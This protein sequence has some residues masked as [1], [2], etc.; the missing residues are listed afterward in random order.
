MSTFTTGEINPEE[1]CKGTSW[2]DEDCESGFSDIISGQ[3]VAK[4]DDV[5]LLEKDASRK[6]WCFSAKLEG[7]RSAL[8]KW[9]SDHMTN[10]FTGLP[11]N[12][13][14]IEFV[15]STDLRTWVST[16]RGEVALKRHNA[17]R[18]MQGIALLEHVINEDTVAVMEEMIDISPGLGTLYGA[19]G[20]NILHRVFVVEDDQT[21]FRLASRM[22]DGGVSVNEATFAGLTLLHMCTESVTRTEFLLHRGANANISSDVVGTPLHVAVR[23]KQPDT[24]RALVTGGADVN[25]GDKGTPLHVAAE[26]GFF[27]IVSLLLELGANPAILH[28]GVDIL[29]TLLVTYNIECARGGNVPTEYFVKLKSLVTEL[30]QKGCNVNGVD[31]HF[32]TPLKICMG[33]CSS[34]CFFAETRGKRLKLYADILTE[35]YDSGADPTLPPQASALSYVRRMHPY[36]RKTLRLLVDP[37]PHTASCNVWEPEEIRRYYPMLAL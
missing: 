14:T 29:F 10:P 5:F 2:K 26:L 34:H 28:G 37:T 23:K 17:T 21:V 32:D 15:K 3:C 35:I 16:V 7:A 31:E 4:D 22:I 30:I 6:G 13:A 33:A 1:V 9:L 11:F 25:F 36:A 12:E 18:I 19:Q 8:G 24:I 20:W 27:E